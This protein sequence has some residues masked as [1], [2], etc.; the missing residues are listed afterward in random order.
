M[1]MSKAKAEN[2]ELPR[3]FYK[4]VT[5]AEGEGGWLV[6][7][8]GRSVKAPAKQVL[9]LPVKALAEQIAAEW[10]AQEERIDPFT[11]PLTRLVHVALDRMGSVREG[12]ADEVAKYASTDSL[13]YRSD[14]DRLAQ[15]QAEVWD[16]YLSWA[17]TAL[18]A[19]LVVTHDISPI[20]QPE[21][22]LVAL[23]QRALALD[24]LRLTGLVS[25]TPILTSA[26]LAFALLEEEADGEAV[27]AASRLEEDFQEEL[28]GEDA[29]AQLAAKNRRRDLLACEVLFRTLDEGG[30][31]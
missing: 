14:D 31:A 2:R 3:R 11:M 4:E 8:D 5:V 23:K 28:W 21:A 1:S 19:P 27:F 26:V 7:L 22:S 15:R 18:D 17:K 10:K 6:H 12:A 9:Q 13:C 30:A 24:D 29:E 20:P 16:P 25:A